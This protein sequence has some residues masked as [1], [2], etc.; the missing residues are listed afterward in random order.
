MGGKVFRIERMAGNGIDG[1]GFDLEA[2]RHQEIMDAIAKLQVA[3]KESEQKAQD[4]ASAEVLESIRHELAETNKIKTEL[5]SIR[6]SIIDTKREIATLHHS[7][8]EGEDSATVS[9][10]LDAVIYG[11]EQAT[12]KILTAAEV[13]ESNAANLASALKSPGEHNMAL[14]I[15]EH[16]VAIF[17]ACNFQDL[18]GQRINKVVNTMRF[19][20]ERI[21]YMI[22][23][24]GGV[25][26]FAGIKPEKMEGK[27]SDAHL[28]NGPAMEDDE[29]IASQ[30]DIDALF[31]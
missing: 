4:Q 19:I 1:E 2:Q 7:G 11:T 21:D 15:Q 23:I 17:E 25:E 27:T 26:S 13:I 12:D 3:P 9:D 30:G 10:E 31:D 29:D 8:F 22:N 16:S 18:T 28:L 14:E 5:D 24:W 20:E 6:T